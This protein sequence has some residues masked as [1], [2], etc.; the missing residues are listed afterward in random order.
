MKLIL[1]NHLL[2]FLPLCILS[3]AACNQ[4]AKKSSTSTMTDSTSQATLPAAKGF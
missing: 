3:L 2:L 1:K 4:T